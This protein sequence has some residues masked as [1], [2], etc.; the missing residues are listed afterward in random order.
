MK[1]KKQ[2]YIITS[3]S[4]FISLFSNFF[5]SSPSSDQHKQPIL[6]SNSKIKDIPQNSH[7]VQVTLEYISFKK[8][9]VLPIKGALLTLEGENT[10]CFFQDPLYHN[11]SLY[12]LSEDGDKKFAAEI[13]VDERILEEILR[14]RN[15]TRFYFLDS[16]FSSSFPIIQQ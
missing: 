14:C 2:I 12:S 1:Y 5:V 8:E 13:A 9:I 15:R 16:N 11:V 4:L 10:K 7:L 3:I 6:T